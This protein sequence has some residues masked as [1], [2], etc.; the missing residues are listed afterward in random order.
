MAAV[1]SRD[2]TGPGRSA[3]RRAAVAL[4]ETHALRGNPVDVGRFEQLLP[5]A[6]QVTPTQVIRKDEHNV[7]LLL[8]RVLPLRTGARGECRG[9]CQHQGTG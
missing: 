4:S 7:G 1:R 5:V 8:G 3:Y 9:S 6:A 2:E